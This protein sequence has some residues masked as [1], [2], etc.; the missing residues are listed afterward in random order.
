MIYELKDT[1]KAKQL[2]A[3]CEETLVISCLE[4]V[5]GKVYVTNPMHPTAAMTSLG[6]FCFYAGD[7]ERELVERKPA[8]TVLMV[9]QNE[10]WESLIETCF[11]YARRVERYAI[12]KNT[13]FDK[14]ALRKNI[15]ALPAGYELAR[16]DSARYDMCMENPVTADFVSAFESKERYLKEGRGFVVLKDGEIVSG[17]SSYSVY[18]GGI[19]IEVD[20]VEG[21]RRRHLAT[22]AC[23]ALILSCLEE[24]LYPSWDAQ[25]MASV[26]LAETL[27]YE[28]SHAYVAY[29]VTDRE[30]E[31]G[32]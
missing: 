14:E 17:A 15:E 16:I 1:E 2:F 23:S 6:C 25:N 18:D 4:G 12:K 11:P 27:G 31:K 19:E 10:R 20:T 26:H 3:G 28:F 24:G 9:P 13:V 22:V 30:F 29:V 7:P 32:I 21:E 5:M 8:G